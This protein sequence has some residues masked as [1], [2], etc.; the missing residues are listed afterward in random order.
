MDRLILHCDLNNF[1]ASVECLKNPALAEAPLAVAGDPEK[2][3]GVILA[4][5][6][7][8]KKFGVK[9]GDVIW[10]ARLKAP[11]LVIVKPHFDD[12]M[13]ISDQVSEI[14]YRF[15]PQ[16]EPFGAD[17]CWLDCTGCEKLFGNG[18]QIADTIRSTV[19]KETGLSIS[20]GVSF[21]K[22][23]A[24]LGSDFKKPDAT[25][26]ITRENFRNMLWGLPADQMLSVGRKTYEKLV[27]MNI[28]TIGDLARADADVLKKTFGVLGPR[29]RDNAL[30]LDSEPVRE[31][32]S[33]RP[34]ESVG[35]GM[36]TVK[37][38]VTMANAQTIIYYLSDMVGA[39]MR[40]YGVRGKTV[41]VH[42]RNSVLKSISRQTALTRPTFAAAEIAEAALSLV[43][44]NWSGEPLRTVTVTVS[45]LVSSDGCVQADM[46][47]RDPYRNE[48]LEKALDSIKAKYGKSAVM[49]ADLIES[50]FVYDK[51]KGEDFLP[52]KR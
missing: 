40:K 12:Y 34:R 3:H 1:Y 42:L 31:H 30:G 10:E 35:H 52:F 13:R 23:F 24:K 20:V 25:T 26:V 48:R 47:D 50:D 45:D 33:R 21:N 15:T 28:V 11:G 44:A 18:R 49:R 43:K 16:V 46:F 17:E 36:T 7:A 27:K 8:A 14:Y 32:G 39:R 2:R 22:V 6:D 29:M 41:T 9:T 37:D 51:N 4:K 19:K 38:V 5:N